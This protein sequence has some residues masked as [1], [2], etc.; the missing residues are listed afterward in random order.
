LTSFLQDVCRDLPEGSLEIQGQEL[1]PNLHV[2]AY[3]AHLERKTR[4]PVIRFD[5]VRNLEGEPSIFPIVTNCFATREA[6]A[7]ALGLGP[8]Q[9]GVELALEYQRRSSAELEPLVVAADDA[10][11][12]EVI[13]PL[14]LREL[15]ILTHHLRDRG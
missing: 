11:C 8:A 5:R 14:D 2:S 6:I 12:K 3:V 9:A 4:Y 15:P 1:D 7:V 13:A 10:P